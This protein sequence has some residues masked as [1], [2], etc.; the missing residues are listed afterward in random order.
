MYYPE[1]AQV[2]LQNLADTL[3]QVKASNNVDYSADALINCSA[4]ADK[5]MKSCII[6][7]QMDDR[8]TLSCNCEGSALLYNMYM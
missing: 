7:L 2:F 6:Y 5:I 1:G 4:T 8:R 3:K